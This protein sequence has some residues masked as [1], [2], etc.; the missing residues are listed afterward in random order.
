MSPDLQLFQV[1]QRHGV[2][3]AIVGG[4]AVNF[5]GYRR[6]TEDSDLVWAR[7]PE[8]EAALAAALAEVGACYIGRDIDPA[9]G[10]ERLYPVS[11]PYIRANHLMML[12][13][14]GG[15][16]D[17]FDFVPDHPGVDVRVLLESSVV[18]DGLRIVSLAW[19]RRMKEVAGR[20]KDLLDLQNLPP[21]PEP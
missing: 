17:L 15:F 5:H 20:Q 2:P 18:V 1:L 11:L 4:H 21:T 8:S 13:T 14:T 9:T 16:L 6:A 19:L 12:W 7:S 10:I 3:F